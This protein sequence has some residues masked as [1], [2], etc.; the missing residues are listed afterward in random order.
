MQRIYSFIAHKITQ[1]TNTCT[2]TIRHILH[3]NLMRDILIYTHVSTVKQTD[4]IRY[5]IQSAVEAERK[6][7]NA[8]VNQDRIYAA[9]QAN[10]AYRICEIELNKMYPCNMKSQQPFT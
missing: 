3:C 6:W 2:H 4:R 1:I 10:Q 9:N 7:V 5:A 8:N